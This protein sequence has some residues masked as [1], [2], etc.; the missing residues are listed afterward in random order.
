MYP[1]E[2]NLLTENIS[3]DARVLYCLGLRPFVDHVSG[4]TPPLNYKQLRSLLNSV[5]EKYHR[6]RQ[7][8]YLFKELHRVGLVGLDLKTSLDHSLNGKHVYLP[9]V[10]LEPNNLSLEATKRV[11]MDKSWL[12][13][14]SIFKDI[15][16]LT[17]LVK[18]DYTQEELGEFVAYWMGRPDKEYSTYQWTQRFINNIKQQRQLQGSTRLKDL[19]NNKLNDKPELT[20]NQNVNR[21]VERYYE[22]SDSKN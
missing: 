4:Q 21:L 13:D 18:P 10:I 11:K 19:G 9:M 8:N 12:P 14:Q 17:G 15:A 20:V 2:I 7:L 3:N 1:S 6:G 22:K 5:D 16:H